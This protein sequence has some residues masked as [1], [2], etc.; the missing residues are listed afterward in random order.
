MG[1]LDSEENKPIVKQPKAAVS[2]YTQENEEYSL[3]PA[4]RMIFGFLPGIILILLGAL[5]LLSQAGYLTGEWWQYFLV[6]MAVIVFLET[7][8]RFR[9]TT[10]KRLKWVRMA[11]ALLMIIGGALFLFNPN[12][13][14]P[15]AL[16]GA[17]VV[18]VFLFLWAHQ[19]EKQ[20]KPDEVK[21]THRQ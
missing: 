18:V 3:N 2:A 12:G 9:A 13:W 20:S 4:M 7:G 21:E 16:I 8:I 5:F 14:W 15:W 19:K 11:S 10:P 17:G 1:I 6:G